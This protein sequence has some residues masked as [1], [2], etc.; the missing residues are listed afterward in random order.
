MKNN[1]NYNIFIN[2]VAS[3]FLYKYNLNKKKYK[4]YDNYNIS[5][6]IKYIENNKISKPIK[7]KIQKIKLFYKITSYKCLSYIGISVD[8]LFT[9]LY[10]YTIFNN[11]YISI[12]NNYIT[13]DNLTSFINKNKINI[14]IEHQFMN[15][16]IYFI[17]NKI[18]FPSN[19]D[20][21][22]Q[23]FL[24]SKKRFFIIPIIIQI[25]YDA[26][27]NVLIYDTLT[28]EI[29]RFEPYSKYGPPNF[30]YNY[31]LLDN[32]LYTYL[33]IYFNNIIYIKSED[34]IPNLNFMNYENINKNIYNDDPN[35]Y[36]SLWCFIYIYY[37]IKYNKINR[38]IIINKIINTIKKN[39]ITFK[40]FVR[41]YSFKI[42]SF[43]D[44]FFNKI[45]ININDFYNND[46][47]SDT[48]IKFNN[49]INIF[50]LKYKSF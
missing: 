31:K 27:S 50:I 2:I 10:L 26:H 15:F 16:E 48:F 47:T 46:I 37:R 23:S 39:N 44:K 43:R 9:Y 25:N 36:C 35:G 33:S 6:I 42:T 40:N 1:D 28:N 7:K 32:L 30:N 11:I 29:E 13:N 5:D 17:N 22:I 8:I 19:F 34:F 3:S 20:N 38:K 4:N 14:L 21:I 41:F 18:I 12:S 45:N 49:L 24:N